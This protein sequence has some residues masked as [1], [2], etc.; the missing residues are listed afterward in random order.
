MDSSEIAEQ[1][2]FDARQRRERADA[3]RLERW[4]KRTRLFHQAYKDA[5]FE[6]TALRI[7]KLQLE[8][9]GADKVLP[10]QNRNLRKR[11]LVVSTERN[12]YKQQHD[13]LLEALQDL[14]AATRTLDDAYGG[15]CTPE[16]V[17]AME[18]AGAAISKAR[19]AREE[20]K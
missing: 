14:Y 18:K 15:D 3:A 12:E 9:Y 1:D 19:A 20:G 7:Q 2:R 16:I 11:L 4:K 5:S 17:S 13:E 6:A 10:M 8:A